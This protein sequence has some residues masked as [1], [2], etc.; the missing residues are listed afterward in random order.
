M[1]DK[2]SDLDGDPVVKSA[3]RFQMQR[4]AIVSRTTQAMRAGCCRAPRRACGMATSCRPGSMRHELLLDGRKA[5]Q[6]VSSGVEG[7]R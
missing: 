5:G 7:R 2:S 4:N 6:L 1:T 3:R